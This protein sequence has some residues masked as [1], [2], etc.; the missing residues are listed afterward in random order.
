MDIAWVD[1]LDEDK[2]ERKHH[3]HAY[4]AEEVLLSRPRVYFVEKGRIEGEDVYLALGRTEAG[5]YLAVFFIYK[6][7]RVALVISAREMDAKERRRYAKK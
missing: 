5:R 3:V 6:Q 7:D 2:L 1:V 4:E